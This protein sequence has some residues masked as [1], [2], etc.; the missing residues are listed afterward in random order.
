M[1]NFG[2]G[3][4]N[5]L[6]INNKWIKNAYL[7]GFVILTTMGNSFAE[8]RL[9]LS[10]SP[11]SEVLVNLS[12]AD[13]IKGLQFVVRASG[14]VKLTGIDK[15]ARLFDSQ[16]GL[17]YYMKND[18]TMSVVILSL[19]QT[20]LTAG[21]GSIAKI[22]LHTTPTSENSTLEL[23]DVVLADPRG[24]GLQVSLSSLVW[25]G[26]IA[27]A[28]TLNQSST[29]VAN[30]QIP[31]S[32]TLAQNFPNPFNP[33]TTIAYRLDTPVSVRLAVY[34][35]SGRAVKELVNG[36][37]ASGSYSV[38]WG[39]KND[40][41]ESVASGTYFTRLSVGSTSQMIKMLLVK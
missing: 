33:S 34:D 13:A 19:G 3:Q 35:M 38:V 9:S 36:Y 40:R 32:F 16:W 30:D 15:E 41:G 27:L 6:R 10:V 8:N 39:G 4:M 24:Q 21:S 14:D 37:Q 18:L 12:N 20:S 26:N 25:Q 11:Q 17:Y 2:K 31:V 23:T 7:L 22:A 29:A 1:N 28:K 5:M